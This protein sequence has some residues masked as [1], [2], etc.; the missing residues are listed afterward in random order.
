MRAAVRRGLF[1]GLL[2][3][4]LILGL[5]FAFWPQPVPVDLATIE[6]GPLRVTVDG[7]GQT[8]VEDV[9]VVSAPLTGR[10]L[11]IDLRPGDVIEARRTVLAMLEEMDPAF[12][13]ERT[14][15][16]LRAELRTA[17]AA[18]ALAQAELDRAQSELAFARSELR[19]AEALGP[20][21]AITE[22][23]LDQARLDVGVNEA[24]LATAEATLRMRDSELESARAALIEPGEDGAFDG[25]GEPCC[26][27]LRSPVSG[28]VLRVLRESEGVVPAG[29]PL[30]EIGDPTDLEVVVDLPSAEAVQVE[31]G[32]PAIIEN[33][34]G[35]Q[36]LNGQVRRVEPYGFTK[37][38]ALGIEE[39]RVN[40]IVD[41]LDPPEA[42]QELGHGYRVL[43]RIVVF[44]ADDVLRV[45]VGALFREGDSWA[46]FVREDGRARLRLVEIGPSNGRLAVVEEGLVAG[47]QVLLHPND[48]IESGIG[49]EP[50][51]IG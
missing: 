22:R 50:R 6:R 35:P 38:S 37:V 23:A 16:R 17:E 44:Q 3:A 33:W 5:G 49:V 45:P 15:A 41:L 20:R 31:P 10:L 51:G 28:E 19:R 34:G 26:V 13:D 24:R 18:Y 2:G 43:V 29:E 36:P 14:R 4:L 7:E 42:W 40:V 39:Q 25:P 27:P 46:V 11:R 32:A 8:R 21:G 47:D 1:M 9:Y 48:Q 30:V 12:L